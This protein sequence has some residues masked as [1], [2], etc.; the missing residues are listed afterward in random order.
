MQRRRHTRCGRTV[1]QQ[2][3]RGPLVVLPITSGVLVFRAGARVLAVNSWERM[4]CHFLP[5]FLSIFEHAS[6][7][8]G[9]PESLASHG[10][11]FL[12]LSRRLNGGKRRA[13]E[14]SGKFG[15]LTADESSS[16]PTELLFTINTHLRCVSFENSHPKHFLST[17]HKLRF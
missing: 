14:Q 12:G 2:G 11:V 5:L 8:R 6:T 3:Q 9:K 15:P 1:P 7:L 13:A 17:N 10:E 16:L 4:C